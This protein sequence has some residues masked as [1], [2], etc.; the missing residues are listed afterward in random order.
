MPT[1]PVPEP[2]PEPAVERPTEPPAGPSATPPSEP[3][4][5][6]DTQPDIPPVTRASLRAAR[7]AEARGRAQGHTGP[8][9]GAAEAGAAGAIS[10]ATLPPAPPAVVAAAVTGVALALLVG[11][12]AS[13]GGVLTALA[14][15][16]A[17]VVMVWGW[18]LLTG[19]PSP[20]SATAVTGVGVLAICATVVLT[21]TEPR[22]VWVPATLA[23]GVVAALLHQVFRRHGRPRLT[24]GIASSVSAL[25]VAAC[26]APLIALVGQGHGDRWIA[27]GMAAVAVAVALITGLR[28][29][30]RAPWVLG[31]TM[32]VGVGVAVLAAWLVSGLPLIAAAVLGLLVS[33]V[34]HALLRVLLD[35]PGAA[36][37]QAAVA[38]GAA[39]VLVVGVLVYLVARVT[40]G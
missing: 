33:A 9:G 27:V 35:L 15:A 3:D 7:E 2:G 10:P 29:R 34:A 8:E 22:L 40:S 31:T 25:A 37:P 20:R 38:A 12:S 5:P 36:S 30:A 26:G 24:E 23:V 17:A 4:I 28:R 21:R 11:V 1:E 32:V 39:S 19:A 16:L 6:P 14:V 13:A 18:A